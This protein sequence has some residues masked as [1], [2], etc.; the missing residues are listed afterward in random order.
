[1]RP[2]FTFATFALALTVAARGVL[3]MP[4]VCWAAP[5]PPAPP[6]LAPAQP[7]DEQTELEKGRNAYRAQKYDEADARFLRMLDPK[8]GILHDRV[9]IKQ[10][11][12]YWAATLIAE[13]HD[14]DATN[15]F[16][17]I[18]T[19]DRNYEPD[20]LAFPTE[21][22][23]AFI[24]TRA[25]L[26]EKLE[27]IEREQY[28][29]AAE[30]RVREEA[31]RKA[32]I[33]RVKMLEQLAAEAEVTE[34]HSRWIAL[35]PFGVGQFQN[36]QKGLGAAFLG[37]EGTLLA[38]AAISIPFYISNLRDSTVVYSLADKSVSQQY[39]DRANTARY[40]NLAFNGALALTAVIGVIQAE[41]AFVPEV[42]K[43]RPRTPPALQVP[44]IPAAGPVLS[45]LS[46]GAAPVPGREGR[47]VTGA[48]VGV[49]ASF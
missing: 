23:N 40:V 46:F 4:R 6:A 39:L 14:E 44:A 20:P 12:M 22:V 41:V 9:L 13:H 49:S 47:G 24:D 26:R 25:R 31:T 3:G 43:L 33:A 36:G 5:V 18:L 8:N 48:I 7:V 30:R 28:R 10:A 11:R 19:D 37:T 38:G 42:V 1:M 29:R 34:K 27:A 32:E 35:L 16:E 21:V 17:V 15:L 45:P 2:R